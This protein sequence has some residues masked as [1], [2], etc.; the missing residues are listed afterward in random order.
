MLPALLAIL[1]LNCHN[2][3][4]SCNNAERYRK[5][6]NLGDRGMSVAGC[7][8]L[9]KSLQKTLGLP[10]LSPQAPVCLLESGSG[11]VSELAEGARLEIA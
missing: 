3:E 2:L 11:E 1:I 5:L 8:L 4:T 9:T 7:E 10:A 6:D